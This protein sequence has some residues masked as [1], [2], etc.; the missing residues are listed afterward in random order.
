MKKNAKVISLLLSLVLL[1]G[2]MAGCGQ[3]PSEEPDNIVEIEPTGASSLNE[4]IIDMTDYVGDHFEK[5]AMSS[6]PALH[7]A[8]MPVAS[9]TTVLQNTK[10]K[11]DA[12]NVADGYIMVA[13]T[14]STTS[15]IKVMMQGPTGTV[16]YYDLSN[17]GA[18][19]VFPLSDGNGKYTVNVCK[20]VS[21]TTYSV[22][23][24]TPINVTLKDEFA[25][26][27]LPNQYVNYNANSEVVKKA[28]ELTAN[29]TDTLGKIEAIYNYVVGNFTYDYHRAETVQPGYLPNVD[30]VLAK[31]TGICFDYAAVMAAMLRSQNIPCKLVVGYAGTVYHAWINCYSPEQGW[32]D[33]VIYFNGSNWQR[34]DPTFASTANSSAA[35]LKYIGDGSNYSAKYLY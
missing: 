9:G 21:G 5:V 7:T 25:P 11:I 10:A 30:D 26:F 13:Y 27:L 1:V 14:E 16:Y 33:A 23:Y 34:M 18:Y 22:S 29:S 24:S 31:R 35:I 32:M 20:N 2:L 8:L 28:A 4:E 15:N 6:G 12:S 3:A 17:S 19:E